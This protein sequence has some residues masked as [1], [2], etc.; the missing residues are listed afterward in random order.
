MHNLRHTLSSLTVTI[1]LT[2]FL[3]TLGAVPA[4][5]NPDFSNVTDILQVRRNLLAIDDLAISWQTINPDNLLLSSL[6]TENGSVQLPLLTVNLAIADN[7]TTIIPFTLMGWMF[8]SL[9]F[10]VTVT[11]INNVYFIHSKA[12]LPAL[13]SGGLRGLSFRPITAAAMGDFDGDGYEDI[14]V[15]SGNVLSLHTAADVND[16][17]QGLKF[18]ADIAVDTIPDGFFIHLTVGD[19]K[20]D[21]KAE[22][23]GVTAT[24]NGGT[25][26]LI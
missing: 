23:A 4:Q 16:P 11:V 12:D 18:I 19:F 17:S 5:A 21:G 3:S 26:I 6:L 7:N 2:A 20:G 25:A 24:Y 1:L 13:A 22:I 15:A 8:A 10:D 14:A 9:N